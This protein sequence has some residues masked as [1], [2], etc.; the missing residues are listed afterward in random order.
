MG[1]VFI[2]Y[3]MLDERFGAAAIYEILV[4]R[5]GADSVFRDCTSL[6]PGEHYPS[7]IL[8]A[9][10]QADLLLAVIGPGW[11]TL[12]DRIG[13]RLLDRR[14]DWVRHEIATAFEHGIPVIPVLLE[15][16]AQPTVAQL[17]P[18]IGRLAL[19]QAAHVSHMG[20]GEDVHR[21]AERITELVPSLVSP[22]QPT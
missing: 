12:R 2:S 13:F 22:A 3:R 16:A 14:H 21:L 11:L 7:V 10:A 8:D 5:F 4:Q 1:K 6:Q 20:L 17:R 18:E 9:V 15:G 19:I